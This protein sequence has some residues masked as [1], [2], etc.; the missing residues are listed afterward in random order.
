MGKS[1]K[2][3]EFSP[4]ERMLEV[5]RRADEARDTHTPGS[6]MRPPPSASRMFDVFF[7]HRSTLRR[8]PSSSLNTVAIAR[9]SAATTTVPCNIRDHP[10]LADDNPRVRATDVAVNRT[11]IWKRKKLRIQEDSWKQKRPGGGTVG[12][13]SATRFTRV[14]SF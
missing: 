8:A 1:R 14:F 9:R 13:S 4:G 7:S 2:I 6:R 12:Q 3:S 5:A 11:R 10:L